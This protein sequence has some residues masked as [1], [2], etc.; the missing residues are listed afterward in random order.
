MLTTRKYVKQIRRSSY[1]PRSVSRKV[2]PP[3]LTYNAG[4]STPA[5]KQPR[6]T[7]FTFNPL[8]IK[9][10]TRPPGTHLEPPGSRERASRRNVPLKSHA[11]AGT[12]A[13]P[14][15]MINTPAVA[16][17][18]HPG[19]PAVPLAHVGGRSS[20]R[21]HYRKRRKRRFTRAARRRTCMHT[22]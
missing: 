9:P 11:R 17:D 2:T 4:A 13:R 22:N 19:G 10:R 6:R 14:R 12:I 21:P 8:R 7:Q 15:T 16:P 1:G 3:R 18:A 20:P 5:S